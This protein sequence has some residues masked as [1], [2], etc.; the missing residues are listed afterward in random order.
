MKRAL[1]INKADP[2]AVF[3]RL[4]TAWIA[5]AALA[6]IAIGCAHDDGTL[7]TPLDWVIPSYSDDDLREL[8]L[9][10]DQQI[11]EHVEIINDPLVAS[12]INQLGQTLVAQI[13]PQP[14]IYRFR[15]IKAKSLN[16]FAIPGGYIYLHSETLMQMGSLDELVGVM[17]HE[18][19]H[20]QARHFSRR[21]SKTALPGLAARILGIGAAVATNQPGLAL[22]GEGVN[23]SLKIGFTR[24][25]EAEADQLAAIW[26]TRAGYDPAGITHFLDKVSRS[27]HR[28]PDSLPPYLNTHPFPEQRIES[29][30]A[31]ADNLRV[32]AKAD[33][34]LE[35]HFSQVQGR[36]AWL[37]D[38]GRTH[39]FQVP[40]TGRD[41]S[42]DQALD[43]AEKLQSEGDLDGALLLLGR[44]DGLETPDPQV[45][46]RIGELLY[47]RG[48]Y[49]ESAASFQR[50]IALDPAPALTFFKLGIALRDADQRHR[51]VYAFEQAALRTPA[52]SQLQKR[53]EWEIFK[54]TFASIEHAFFTDDPDAEEFAPVSGIPQAEFTTEIAELVWKA[55]V[56]S[57]FISHIDHLEVRWLNPAGDIVQDKGAERSGKRQILSVLKFDPTHAPKA[58]QWKIE[59]RLSNE[60]I[61]RRT[62]LLR[63][64]PGRAVKP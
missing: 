27:A 2:P 4:A 21:E 32:V 50:S 26:A 6:L 28:F 43:D 36:L 51:A 12:F 39:N 45:P 22:A 24:E 30:L 42:T 19:A 60:V 9:G 47:E 34:A 5:V 13:E 40:L 57:R 48:R 59:L 17:S 3:H 15:V 33:P 23:V 58:G 8:G 64:S 7:S 14:F 38:T 53:C 63:P 16:A 55:Q 11:Q 49:Q 29:I 62:V 46:Y 25:F 54:L 10:A 31:A 52:T 35:E 1:L 61:E 44:V 20:V 41:P 18:I 37:L 56:G